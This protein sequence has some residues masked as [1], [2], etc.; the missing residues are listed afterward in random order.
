MPRLLAI[1]DDE[2][3]RIF[4]KELLERK[5]Y[6]IDL[7]E[8]GRRALDH[9]E[10]N[11]YDLVVVDL[12]MPVMSGFEVLDALGKR[13]ERIPTLITSG[14]IVP[15]VH[16]FLKTHPEMKLLSK[17]YTPEQLLSAIKE[18]LHRPLGNK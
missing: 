15:G 4:L 14:I 1:E 13:P 9:L 3:L 8:D 18:L 5:G 12:L 11:R 17:P 16:D 2:S 6:E 10:E 7:A